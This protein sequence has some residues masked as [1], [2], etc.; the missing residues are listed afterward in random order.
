LDDRR[1]TFAH[2]IL[3]EVAAFSVGRTLA[4]GHEV[5]ESLFGTTQE[6]FL[7]AVAPQNDHFA[8]C[9]TMARLLEA[10]PVRH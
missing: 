8:F 6:G 5:E 9:R 3:S 2:V 7:V 1:H 10:N 4:G